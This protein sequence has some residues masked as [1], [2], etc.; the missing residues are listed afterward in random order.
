[1]ARHDSWTVVVV[2]NF[3]V[4]DVRLFFHSQKNNLPNQQSW[5]QGDWIE[6]KKIV[7]LK[8]EPAGAE[9]RVDPGAQGV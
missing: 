4:A 2:P 1:M 7:Q 3:G 5:I 8:S 9:A 6:L